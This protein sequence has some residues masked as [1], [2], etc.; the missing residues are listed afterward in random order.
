MGLS[1][2]WLVV[3]I[4]DE[5]VNAMLQ[6]T[7]EPPVWIDGEMV[8]GAQKK[9]AYRLENGAHIAGGNTK[10]EASD[11]L[12]AVAKDQKWRVFQPLN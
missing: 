9:Y 6:V 3:Q 7:T 10:K 4:N 2:D 5:L 12:L 11:T 1:K 8:I